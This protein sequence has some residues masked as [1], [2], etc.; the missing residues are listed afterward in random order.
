[1]LSR[2]SNN[3]H[4]SPMVNVMAIR[5]RGPYAYRVSIGWILLVKWVEEVREIKDILLM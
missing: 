3:W 4:L 2:E 5:R 1:M